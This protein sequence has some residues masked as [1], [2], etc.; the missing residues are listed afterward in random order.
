[1]KQKKENKKVVLISSLIMIFLSVLIVAGTI[2]VTLT[3]PVNNAGISGTTNSFICSGTSTTNITNISLFTNNTGEW[4]IKSYNVSYATEVN[5]SLAETNAIAP[6]VSQAKRTGV[7]IDVK[8]EPIVLKKVYNHKG[9]TATMM[10]LTNGDGTVNLTNASV[11]DDT[12][13][14]NNYP[15]QA[16][17]QY[18]IVGDALGE[19]FTQGV[20]YDDCPNVVRSKINFTS[21]VDNEGGEGGG[22]GDCFMVA[23][24]IVGSYNS[25]SYTATF[26]NQQFS[27]SS[28]WNCKVCDIDETCAL[29]TSNYTFTLIF[30]QNSISYNTT[31]YETEDNFITLNIT[32]NGTTPTAKLFYNGTNKGS[33]IVTAYGGNSFIINKTANVNQGQGNTTFYFEINIGG[34][35]INTTTYQQKII[36][37]YFAQCNTTLTIPY[38]NFTF[39]DEENSTSIGTSI[40]YSYFEYYLGSNASNNKTLTYVNNTEN[41]NY[42]FCFSP[43]NKT[44]NINSYLQYTRA[45]YYQRTYNPSVLQFSNKTN[46]TILYSILQSSSNAVTF[47][48]VNSVG[49]PIS[50]VS[51]NVT[52]LI[53]ST[54]VLVGDGTTDAAGA[55]TFYLSPNS[56]YNYAFYKSGYDLYTTSNMPTSPPYTITLGG[57]SS[58]SIITKKDYSQGMQYWIRPSSYGYLENGTDYGFNFTLISS[59]YDVDSFGF[60]LK[61]PNGSILQSTSASS[62]GGVVNV[63]QNT[64]NFEKI[65]INAYWIVEGNYTNVT[66]YWVMYDPSGSSHSLSNFFSRLN[67]Y[68]S[69]GL[70]GMDVGESGY[71]FTLTLIIFVSMFFFV[72]IM[73]YKFGITNVGTISLIIF[74]LVAIV[75][76]QMGLLPSPVNAIPHL[77]TMVIGFI[78][79][80]LIFKEVYNQ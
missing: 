3:S 42:T 44:V 14:F 50:G 52:R 32:T 28:V 60:Y 15:L 71:S 21:G 45:N 39:K 67:N 65:I 38:I 22:A 34:N 30:S 7:V 5:E 11:V 79:V 40:P 63:N 48:V 53:G 9:A 12:V 41:K 68:T 8:S 54:L 66:S 73:T 1:M 37:I 35:L 25:T 61:L 80:V 24:V 17:T 47:L 46:E 62:N 64:G 10:Y 51:V 2:S 74:C 18:W 31:A 13:D 56:I 36:P 78:A 76:L 26:T 55:V 19:S 29:A 33:A 16:N 27:N 58:S 4:L 72:G 23:D 49:D 70:F 6:Q 43:Q 20:R 69:S 57:T 77:P 59:Y 75:D